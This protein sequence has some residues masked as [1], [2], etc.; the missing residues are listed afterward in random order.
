MSNFTTE[1][2]NLANAIKGAGRVV[3]S[4]PKENASVPALIL[5]PSDPYCVPVAIGNMVH[6]IQLQF[7]ISAIVSGVDNQAGLANIEKLMIDVLSLLPEGTAIVS[8]WSAPRPVEISGQQV[9]ES[10]MT[11]QLVTTK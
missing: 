4:F 8:G 5:I 2:T 9:I 11:V 7:D 3:F 10:T 6:R 1:R